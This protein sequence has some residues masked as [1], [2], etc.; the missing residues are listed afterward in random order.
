MALEIS[1]WNVQILGLM[2]WP[3]VYD[4]LAVVGR[5]GLY[6]ERF[7]WLIVSWSVV[8]LGG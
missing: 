3:V 7:G 6:V 5:R 2:I 4:F 8:V 1:S